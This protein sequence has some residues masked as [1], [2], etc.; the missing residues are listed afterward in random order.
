MC[1]K[2][3]ESVPFTETVTITAAVKEWLGELESQ[4]RVTLSSLLETAHNE[5]P[6]DDAKL[7]AWVHDY[8]AQVVILASQVAWTHNVERALSQSEGDLTTAQT[9]LEA[10]LKALSE[11]VLSEMAPALRQ[12][13]EQLLTEMVHQRDVLR[14]LVT[15]KV[16]SISDF[17]WMYH[18]RFYWAS[19]HNDLKKKLSICMSNASFHYGFEYLGIGE[20][21]VQTPLTD[22]CY[23]TLTQALHHGLGA[24]P[25]GPAGTGKTE[26]VKMLGAQ[27][28]RFVLVFNCDSAF[29]YAAMGRIFSGLCQVGAWG[30]F[31]EFN[32]LEERILSAVSQ[33][34]L[35]IQRGLLMQRDSIEFMG[36][37]CKLNKDVGIFVTLNPG[38]AGRS[39]LPDN[40][41]QLFRAVAMVAPDGKIIAQVMLF[42]QGIVTAEDLAGKIVLLFTLCAE[43]L[44]SQLHYD[45][46]LRALKSVLTG[47][48]D[49]K[50]KAIKTKNTDDIPMAAI[51]TDV[52]IKSTCDSVM[53]KLVSEDIPLFTSLLSAVFPS[54][55]IP[56]ITE[57][58]L[59]DAIKKTCEEDDLDY[60]SAWAEKVLQLK[61]VLDMRHGVILVGPSG[62]G[63]STAWKTLLKALSKVDGVK[64]DY[65][66]IDPKSIKKEKLYGSLDP[67]TL[68][69]TDGVFTKTLRRVSEASSVRGVS[70]RSWIVFDGDVD[71]DWAENLNSVLDDNKVLTLPSGDRLKIPDNVRIMMEV[72]SLKHAT[73]ATVSRCGMVWFAAGTISLDVALKQRLRVLRKGP[74]QVCVCVYVCVCVCECVCV[75]VGVSVWVWV[76]NSVHL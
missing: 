8:P 72:D 43:Q 6:T 48:G 15:Q 58:A 33:Q 67:N 63:K 76:C 23:L 25:F 53:P 55:S 51:E 52:L 3:G 12:K 2:E 31:D 66:V 10:R 17:N 4:M 21:L 62:T 37:T 74:I 75:G 35:T 46:G 54:S 70:R 68:E 13:C 49:L 39:N 19:D 26:S 22:R 5:M 16:Q 7:L 65:Y 32:R 38:Y 41:K 45:F 14:I 64:G 47:A 11:S 20:R 42:S 34:I 28:G 57:A 73:L 69:W 27:L 61:Q 30:C 18:L 60:G 40:L 44:S 36:S 50:R 1:S 24:N 56:E 29:D 59:V 71:P 9:V